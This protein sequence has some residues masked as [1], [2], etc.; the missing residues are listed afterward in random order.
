MSKTHKN[1]D[2]ISKLFKSLKTHNF[3]F[4]SILCAKRLKKSF[5]T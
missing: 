3:F 4:G 5:R 1:G 2:E